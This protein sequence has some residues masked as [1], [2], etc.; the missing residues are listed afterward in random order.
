MRRIIAALFAALTLL[1]VMATSSS[2]VGATPPQEAVFDDFIVLFPDLNVNKSVWINITARDFCNWLASGPEGP[3]PAI[4]PVIGIGVGTGQGAIVG[5]IDQELHIELWEFDENPSP[6]IGPCEDIAQ[7]LADPEA[8]PWATGTARFQ[9]KN[10][11]VDFTGTRGVSFGD[12]TTAQV[13][14]QAG[15]EYSY[16]NVFRLNGQCQTPEFAPPAC[17]VDNSQLQPR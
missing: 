17:L 8:E 13:V 5:R 9:A 2:P 14:D 12:R 6:L 3:P 4:D 15:N 7:Q 1:G 10:N 11:D 16:R